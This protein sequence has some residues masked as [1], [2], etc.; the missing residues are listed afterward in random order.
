[1]S[2]LRDE[3]VGGSDSSEERVLSDEQRR[4]AREFRD[5]ELQFIHCLDRLAKQ[6]GSPTRCLALARTNVEQ[7][8]MWALKEVT[9]D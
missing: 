7:A 3:R 4:Q 8:T 9:G 5:L 1:M 6:K 2:I